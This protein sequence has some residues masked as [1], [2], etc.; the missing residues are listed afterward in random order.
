MAIYHLIYRSVAQKALSDKELSELLLNSRTYNKEEQ[1]TG[2]LLH[3]E[4]EYMQ[5]L[6]GEEAAIKRLYARI[7][8][9]HRHTEV[10]MVTDGTTLFRI[11]P[12]WSMGFLH[13]YKEDFLRLV[14]YVDPAARGEARTSI[15]AAPAKGYLALLEEFA[16]TQPVLF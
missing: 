15:G 12:R 6:E 5:V 7:E 14:G 10:R 3:A 11:F 4:G 9:D 2:I 13:V 8:A 1:I 16:L